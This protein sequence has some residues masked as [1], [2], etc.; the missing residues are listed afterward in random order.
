MPRRVHGSRP[1]APATLSEPGVAAP[2]LARHARATVAVALPRVAS[3]SE[4]PP[5]ASPK[6]GAAA[7][8]PAAGRCGGKNCHQLADGHQSR[9]VTSRR[10]GARISTNPPCIPGQHERRRAYAPCRSAQ[11][12]TVTARSAYRP[13]ATF[14]AGTAGVDTITRATGCA[15]PGDSI[16]EREP[17][18][19]LCGRMC[20]TSTSSCAN[21]HERFW[22]ERWRVVWRS[23]QSPRRPTSDADRHRYT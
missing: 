8:C 2:F 21:E 14:D 12:R 17:N 16:A 7:C 4:C 10:S 18:G 5:A 9:R 15:I 6:A 3:E 20:A 23:D 1:H 13:N 11:L 19:T 22:R